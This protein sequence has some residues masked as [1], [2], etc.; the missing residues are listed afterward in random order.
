MVRT[1]RDGSVKRPVQDRVFEAQEPVSEVENQRSSTK[2]SASTVVQR[3][4]IGSGDS[5]Y[6][7]EG[8]VLHYL[9]MI[10][11]GIIQFNT[12]HY[13]CGNTYR[14]VW[15]LREYP[16]STKEQ[17]ILRN[18]GEMDGVTLK[19]ETR[20][21]TPQEERKIITNA[22]NKNKMKSANT[23]NLKETIE[24]TSN[25][26]DVTT[27]LATMHRNRE[28]L[29]HTAV[30]IE[31][32]AS[33]MDGLKLLQTETLTE[34]N[35][36]KLNVDRLILRQKQGFLS[37][38]PAGKNQFKEQ[39]ERV[40]PASSVANLFPFNYSG[41]TDR[42]G[43]YI[44]RDRF[45]SN[46]IV[47][48]NHRSDDKTNANILILGNS[49]QG[50]SYLLKLILTILREQ[51][52]SIICLDPEHEYVELTRN[53][54]GC[55][56]D[57]MSGEYIIN[58]L[59]PKTW[60][61]GLN[62]ESDGAEEQPRTF[63]I[64]SKLSQHI[65]F[66]RDFFRS[67]KTFT[68]AQIDTIELM[69]GKLYEK[70]G[71]SD[72]TDFSRLVPTDYPILSDLYDLMEE[73]YKNYNPD[74]KH[75]YTAKALQEICLGLHSM[76]KGAESKFFNGYT[77]VEA[78]A[79]ITF[80]VKGLL[81]ASRNVK[82]ALLFN[83]LSYMSNELLTK[84]KTA[85]SIDEFYLFLSNITAVEYIRN[86]SKRV[87]KKDSSVILA[88]QNLEDFNIDGIREYTKPLFSIPTH[89]FLFNA[90][91]VDEEFYK[92]SLQIEQSEY[93][94][95]RYPQRGVCLYKCGN[96]RYNLEVHAPEYKE[97]LFG[98]AGGR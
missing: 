63:R 96:E 82:D 44:G 19:I 30:F 6:M 18:L 12:D 5:A 33:D 87:R 84:G 2:K 29:F 60:D 45:G 66:L 86:F 95:I 9:D 46:I 28:P 22:A 49:G 76:C 91:T 17:A 38:N 97:A 93:E 79:F 81:Q 68:D 88:S 25:L 98:S 57:L 90:G 39:Y 10:A 42:N 64:K 36:A 40:L 4:E 37:V 89:A 16:T 72:E 92:D 3:Q 77:N 51:G 21:V 61:E 67:Y 69:L 54:G 15:A 85:A 7:D 55:F 31:L 53:L 71:L 27:M 34:L 74:E 8:R 20:Q 59:E 62:N 80:G 41:K 70:F 65:S 94:L 75:L 83:V 35:N 23:D 24:A 73:E 56:I 26:Q 78:D 47:D 11:P 43:F 32:A 14:C 52:M 48:F 58:V 13:I 50:K 1:S